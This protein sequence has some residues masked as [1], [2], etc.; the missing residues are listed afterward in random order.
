[1]K[2]DESRLKW[3]KLMKMDESGW[4]WMKGGENWIKVDENI[5]GGGTSIS[6]AILSKFCRKI[7]T[8]SKLD[9]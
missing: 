2:R 7:Q 1:M 5:C 4:K 6:E 8:T 9:H 3:I